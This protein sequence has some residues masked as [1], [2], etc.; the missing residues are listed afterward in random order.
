MNNLA[1]QA[2][3]NQMN[4]NANLIYK[5]TEQT[6]SQPTDYRTST[7]KFA[8]VDSMRREVR[9]FLANADLV[10]T[11]N[12]NIVAQDLSDEELLFVIQYKS[13]IE[14]DFKGRDVPADV[15]TKYIAKLK[16]KTDDTFGV[17]YGLQQNTGE[18]ILMGNEKIIDL[19]TKND[20]ERLLDLT[21]T[22][23]GNA[24]LQRSAEVSVSNLMS[25]VL[26]Q[27]DYVSI[28]SL[29]PADKYEVYSM[30]NE[31]LQD[32]PTK[33]QFAEKMRR[34]EYAKEHPS[35]RQDFLR[36]VTNTYQGNSAHRLMMREIEQSLHNMKLQELR[37]PPSYKRDLE[38]AEKYAMEI[39]NDN[40]FYNVTPA[41]LD[42]ANVSN[43]SIINDF[44]KIVAPNIAAWMRL[45]DVSF[46][47][48]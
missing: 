27:Q 34:G 44:Y 47:M 36:G 16:E 37:S 10:N 45:N 33:A 23:D 8:D 19:V 20:L 21:R 24:S 6:P 4:Y 1:L 28:Q 42:F 46:F 17:D 22:L 41:K 39:Q 35:L 11:T 2:S 7:E 12:A 5:N 30:L 31:T 13:F 14:K 3:N 48:L 25:Q 32:V 43:D 15:L 38:E 40:S 9:S 29:S 26:S 18:G